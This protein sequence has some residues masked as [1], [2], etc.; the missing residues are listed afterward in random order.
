MHSY[1]NRASTLALIFCVSTPQLSAAESAPSEIEAEESVVVTASR[2]GALPLSAVGSAVSVISGVELAERQTRIISDVLRDVPGIAVNRSGSPGNLTQI[3]LRGAEGNHTLVYFG[4]INIGDP[5]NGE[6]DL[7]TLL[8]FDIEQIEI[9]RGPQSALYGSDAIGG[10][11]SLLPRRG[12]G[13]LSFGGMAEAGSFGTTLFNANAGFGEEAVD[14]FASATRYDSDGFN[15]SRFGSEDDGAEIW[16]GFANAGF[17]PFSN[18]ELR[19][20]VRVV[21]SQADGDPQDF[22]FFSPTQG[23]V[24]DGDTRTDVDETQAIGSAALDLIDGHW[25]HFLSYAWS[26]STRSSLENG[27]TTFKSE[28]TRAKLSYQSSVFFVTGAAEHFLTGAIDYTEETYLNVALGTPGPANLE[29]ETDQTGY[30]LEYGAA[31]GPLTVSLAGRYDDN[32]RF[33][34][35]ETWRA[36]LSYR[37]RDTATRLRASAGT[38]IK[39]PTNFELFGYDPTSF[40]G[41]PDLEPEE[42]EGFDIGIDQDVLGGK[43]MVS[44]TYFD[45]ELKNEIYTVYDSSFVASPRNRT[46]T[47]TRD[48]VEV[49]ASATLAPDWIIDASYTYLRSEE[50]G[51]EE[52]RRPESIAS[53]NLTHL[54]DAARGRATLTMRYN[55]EQIDNEYIYSNLSDYVTL[56]EYLLVNFSASYALSEAVTLS[57]RIENLFDEDYEEVFSYRGA[58]IGAY[59]GI[60]VQL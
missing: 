50:N 38:G 5:F 6:A 24:I 58:G 34:D 47:S 2:S 14:V 53:V 18:L 39:N 44:I 4:G 48:G 11:I 29:R 23:Y 59:A 1:L 60:E 27:A 7:S 8:A 26:E 22:D 55:G 35:A 10:V 3:R 49:S 52:V 15:I 9:L 33:D 45:S 19:G 36:T 56:E 20:L 28:G 17:R 25:T 42:S 43:G 46:T 13:D 51:V 54:F 31:L 57:G 21:D 30:V 37:L 12:E 41:N 16:S 32:S 40:I